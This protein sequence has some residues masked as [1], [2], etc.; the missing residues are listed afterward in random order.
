MRLVIEDGD[1]TILEITSPGESRYVVRSDTQLARQGD[2]VTEYETDDGYH[3]AGIVMAY[4]GA[5]DSREYLRRRFNE[6]E[7]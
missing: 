7:A 5:T 1:R 3:V 2:K 4:F 6:R